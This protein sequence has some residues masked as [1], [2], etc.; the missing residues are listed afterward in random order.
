MQ[1]AQRQNGCSA[2]CRRPPRPDMPAHT[3]RDDTT[4]LHTCCTQQ[5]TPADM[6]Q[7]TLQTQ[8]AHNTA[9]L[10][11]CCNHNA[12]RSTCC[13]PR[14]DSCRPNALA[15]SCGKLFSQQP[16]VQHTVFDL[17]RTETN[18][19]TYMQLHLIVT[20]GSS[21]ACT[22]HSKLVCSKASRLQHGTS[23]T[24]HPTAQ[25]Q[26]CVTK[27]PQPCTTRLDQLKRPRG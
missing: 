18:L 24:Q 25:L 4:R 2:A 20:A 13:G 23:T 6:L 7:T 11:T 8:A 21:T 16:Y 17:I 22:M 27:R 26:Q 19:A 9:S 1:A 5:H 14:T 15:G 3:L 12:S 10:H